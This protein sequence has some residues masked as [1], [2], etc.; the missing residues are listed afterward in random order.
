M[1]PRQFNTREADWHTDNNQLSTIRHL[2]F[3][4]EQKVPKDEE[5]DGKDEESWHWLATDTNDAPIGTARLLPDGQIG[6]MAVLSNYRKFGVGAALLEQAVEKARHLGFS[7]VFLNAQTHALGFYEK[8]GFVA[9]GEEFQEADIA[10]YRMTQ[11][12]KTLS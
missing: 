5:W 8:A 4:V 3:I 1:E 12:L 10:H 9:E 6:R 2:V 11:A 7:S